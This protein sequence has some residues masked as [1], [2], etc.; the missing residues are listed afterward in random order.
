MEP[1]DDALMSAAAAGDGAAFSVLIERHQRRAWN[2]ACRFLGNGGEAADMVQKA[3][4]RILQS[5]QRYEGTGTFG[6]YLRTVVSRLCLDHCAKKRAVPKEGFS[7]VA[8]PPDSISSQVHQRAARSAVR[9]ALDV[10][11]PRQRM[12]IVLRYYDGAGYRDI[13]RAL[14]VSPKAVERL[15][16]RGRKRLGELLATAVKTV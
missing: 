10:L 5:L 7:G 13:G 15:L 16:D 14:G 3:F 11:P 8:A 4:M 2:I 1:S 9:H 12:A 6:A